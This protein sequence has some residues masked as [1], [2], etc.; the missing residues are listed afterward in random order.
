MRL[1]LL[2]AILFGV[3]SNIY[4]IGIVYKQVYDY[5]RNK[6]YKEGRIAD[7]KD[8]NK[9]FAYST[10]IPNE[11]DKINIMIIDEN[12]KTLKFNDSAHWECTIRD[13]Y[14]AHD[15]TI[16]IV[17]F[18][19]IP[20]HEITYGISYIELDKNLNIIKKSYSDSLSKNKIP[21]PIISKDGEQI[22]LGNY[23][24]DTKFPCVDIYNTDCN[25]IESKDIGFTPFKFNE[26]LYS[27]TLY[28]YNNGF[29]LNYAFSKPGFAQYIT[30]YK[31]DNKLNPIIRQDFGKDLLLSYVSLDNVNQHGD[32]L[33][34]YRDATLFIFRTSFLNSYDSN[35][36]LNYTMDTLNPRTIQTSSKDSLIIANAAVLNS[37]ASLMTYRPRSGYEELH[38][39]LRYV[40]SAGKT[41]DDILFHQPNSDPDSVT[42]G[43]AAIYNTESGDV[44][45][46]FKS[47]YQGE[48]W[49]PYKTEYPFGFAK[50]VLMKL[51]ESVG[52]KDISLHNT[53][54]A[55]FPNPA[56]DFITINYDN[57]DNNISSPAF[58]Y[59]ILGLQ[60]LQKSFINSNNKIDISH[61]TP[62]V[63]F[64]KIG[65]R[66]EK[67]VKI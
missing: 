29:Y 8:G 25:L 36:E 28:K 14:V 34:T 2:I 41:V 18:R 56:T 13:L 62:G 57:K 44:F 43:R 20:G 51:D 17:G 5:N 4:S 24:T 6:H 10:Q 21:N 58:I 53:D 45:I 12:G 40:N 32:F 19:N 11:S 39:S 16:K 60:V 61:L 52:V 30:L 59:D 64:I 46:A 49:E 1:I 15:N 63:Y 3:S 26:Q 47:V 33:V 67:F 48:E 7:L 38:S 50:V 22:L 9:V 31:L 42:L 54:V 66:I 37:G 23:N 55:I 27:I 65:N 35:F